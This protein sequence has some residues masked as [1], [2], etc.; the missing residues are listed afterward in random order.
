MTGKRLGYV[1]VSSV[2]QNS[3]R[4]LVD[5]ELDKIFE[6]KLSGKDMKRPALQEL[7]DYC[8][9]GDHIVCHSLDRLCRSV[10][11]L[12]ELL[13][14]F[15]KKGVT[16]EFLKEKLSFAPNDT[17]HI[18]KFQLQ[19]LGSVAELE[20]NIIRERQR[21]GIV[22]ARAK[23][24]FTGSSKL[25]SDAQVRDMIDRIEAGEV[26]AKVISDL[27]RYDVKRKRNGNLVTEI[28]R[29]G[30]IVMRKRY[31]QGHPEILSVYPRLKPQQDEAA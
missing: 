31:I 16:I 27:G 19:I 15:G 5:I 9:D 17:N 26:M 21:E 13:D 14:I 4:Q 24:K 23:K 30:F 10:R 29:M 28:S 2:G 18:A 25:F 3:D 8:R 6:D 11:D 1:R 20:R 12:L 22:L 7:L